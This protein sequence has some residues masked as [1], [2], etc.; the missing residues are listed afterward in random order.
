MILPPNSFQPTISFTLDLV[1]RFCDLGFPQTIP[2]SSMTQSLAFF[3]TYFIRRGNWQERMFVVYSASRVINQVSSIS[4]DARL[5]TV[6]I[7]SCC[8]NFFLDYMKTSSTRSV[9]SITNLFV[10]SFIGVRFIPSS[11]EQRLLIITVRKELKYCNIRECMA[12]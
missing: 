1:K 12:Q 7:K 8:L 6:G 3:P 10:I 9:F 4:I 2:L 11:Q 5:L